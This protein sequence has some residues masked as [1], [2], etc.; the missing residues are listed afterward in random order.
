[1][2]RMKPY[3]KVSLIVFALPLVFGLIVLFVLRTRPDKT[4]TARISNTSA[5]PSF[6]VVVVK[7]RVNRPLFGL[8]PESDLRFDHTSP[9]ARVG[10]VEPDRLELSADSWDLLIEREIEGGI[11]STTRLVF[12]IELGGRQVK[13]RCR[14]ADDAVGYLRTGRR[15]GSPAAVVLDGE[16]LIEFAK[17]ENVDSGRPINWPSQPI[18]LRGSFA[19]LPWNRR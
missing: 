8:I 1:M 10:S 12:P 4:V 14:P 7:A 2:G 19:G 3:I 15:A 13:L 18:T 16:F 5:G 11:A 6:E 17:C 9:G